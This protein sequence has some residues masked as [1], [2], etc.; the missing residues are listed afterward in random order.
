MAIKGEISKYALQAAINISKDAVFFK[1]LNLK[2]QLANDL[3]LEYISKELKDII[4][5]TDHEIF[6]KKV[7]DKHVAFNKKLIKTH[8]SS[9]YISPWILPKTKEEIEIEIALHPIFNQNDKF[10]GLLGSVHNMETHNKLEDRQRLIQNVFEFSAEGMIITDKHQKITAINQAFTEITGYFQDELI[11]KMPTIL[12]SGRHDEEFYSNM[13]KELQQNDLW[14]GE[15]INRKKSGEEYTEFLTISVIRNSMGEIANYTGIFSDITNIKKAQSQLEYM[16]HHDPLTGLQ[17]R[18]SLH[19]HAKEMIKRAK[20]DSFM[21]GVLFFD[22]D[23]FKEIND[24]YGHSIGDKILIQ[25]ALRLKKLLRDTDMICRLGG[26]EFIILVEKFISLDNFKQVIEKVFHIFKLPFIVN[27]KIF[28][29]TCSLG[30]SIY[31]NDG[32]DLETLIKNADVAM[33]KAKKEGRNTYTL[34]TSEMTKVLLKKVQV[35][36][37]IRRGVEK[38]EFFLQYQPQIDMRTNTIIGAE[39]LVRWQHPRKGLVYPDDFIALAEENKMIIHIGNQVLKKACIDI[40]YWL[41][42]GIN[43][44]DFKIAV[45]ISAV[46]LTSD[47]LYQTVLNIT[48]QVGISPKYL[49]IELTETS[50]M[51][52]PDKAIRLFEKL[53]NLGASLSIDDFGTGYSSLGYLKKFAINQI[54]IDKSFIN[55]IP[56]DKDDI[57]ITRTVLALG[58]SMDLTVVAEGVEKVLQQDFL[59]EEGCIKAQGYLYAPALDKSDLENRFLKYL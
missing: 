38:E 46:Q 26:D 57:A 50:I 41:E 45:N 18:L 55:D 7:A 58:R 2:Y 40:K 9:S 47:D 54:K 36:S 44:K 4:G 1:D 51:Q 43:L 12:A 39:A 42:K 37:D 27:D 19:L 23:H 52:N 22:I 13:W 17:N 29:I 53:Q 20:R 56:N 49:T 59:L 3:F 11:G 28:N 24:S 14:R 8:K 5:K 33:Y 25:V 31:P 10:I 6:P 48:K 16:A 15:V 35:T 21:V 34:Y 30:A 32:N